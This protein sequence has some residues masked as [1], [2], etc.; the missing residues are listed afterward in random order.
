MATY[1]RLNDTI[2]IKTFS[3]RPNERNRERE[4]LTVANKMKEILFEV[5]VSKVE[6]V[7]I[8]GLS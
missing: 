4:I 5:C 2:I 7:F 3:F 8:F 1:F 6:K